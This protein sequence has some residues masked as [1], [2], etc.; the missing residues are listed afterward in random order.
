MVLDFNEKVMMMLIFLSIQ[1]IVKDGG[2]IKPPPHI[3]E[4]EFQQRIF[5][6]EQSGHTRRVS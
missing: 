6:T 1:V 3:P 4:D 5:Q 2:L